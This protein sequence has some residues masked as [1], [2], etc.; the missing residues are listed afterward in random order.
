MRLLLKELLVQLCSPRPGW[1]VIMF[2]D[3][4][5][6]FWDVKGGC[7]IVSKEN[8]LLPG[9][10]IGDVVQEDTR[11]NQLVPSFGWRRAA[12]ISRHH[13]VRL[14]PTRE[15]WSNAGVSNL[16][17]RKCTWHMADVLSIDQL[18]WM[19]YAKL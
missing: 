4:S 14:P 8:D 9:G 13:R 7:G 15:P 19:K 17:S 3:A 1:R 16:G 18:R 12:V 5:D 6:R 10:F 11:Y 2:P